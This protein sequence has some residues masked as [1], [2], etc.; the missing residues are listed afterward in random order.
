MKETT[1]TIREI[2]ELKNKLVQELIDLENLAETDA[3]C[4]YYH[5]K[6]KGV[7]SFYDLIKNSK[8]LTLKEADDDMPL[9]GE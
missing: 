6:C 1:Y 7:E 3:T 4:M 8:G 9:I 5:N 2:A